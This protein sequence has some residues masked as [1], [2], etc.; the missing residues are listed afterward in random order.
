MTVTKMKTTAALR[1]FMLDAGLLKYWMLDAGFL[2]E[3]QASVILDLPAKLFAREG[4]T[5]FTLPNLLE[6]G[7]RNWQKLEYA[8]KDLPQFRCSLRQRW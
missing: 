5:C 7:S 3:H 6:G 1:A 2:I 8:R 4:Y